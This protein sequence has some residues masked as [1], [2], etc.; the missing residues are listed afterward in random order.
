M[1]VDV[2]LHVFATLAAVIALGS[3]LGRLLRAVGQPAVIGEVAAGI[4]LGPSLLGAVWPAALHQLMPPASL[5]PGGTVPAAIQAVAQLGV[6]LYMFLVGLELDAGQLAGRARATVAVAL[7]GIAVP[8]A[9]GAGLA[10]AL[11]PLYGTDTATPLSFALF[12]G[13]AMAVTAFPVLA[14]ILGDRG[15]DRTEI[16]RLAL[17]AAAA[18]DVIAWCLL[19]GVVG[20]ARAE[21]GAAAR[22]VGGALAFVAIMLLLVRPLARRLARR[23]D[24]DTGP[25]PSGAVSLV[26]LGVLLSALAT[27]VIGIHALFG[28]F[29]F[30]A[31][32]PHDGRLAREFDR[33]LHAPVTVCLLPAFFAATG[34]K[35][36][37]GLVD[38]VSDWLWCGAVVLVATVGKVGGT[39][40]A[41]R[42]TG[43]GWRD[44]LA[45]GAL[46]NTRGLME[47]IVLTV[48]LDLGVI[49]PTVFAMMVLMA[50]ATTL[51]TAPAL[52]ALRVNTVPGER[53]A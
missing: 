19:A 36:R 22:V 1:K 46:M 9:L 6:V 7:A 52:A 23:L 48:G 10:V 37:I 30:G 43:H 21:V 34:M 53:E 28:A 45:V 11:Y 13:V 24:A 51:M 26:F 14:R 31:I 4:L 35:T 29:L 44:A 2:V 42:L 32:L 15:L 20:V 27:E 33:M 8:F 47:L 50:L 25:L 17:A 18:G 39:A 41:A 3:L 12:L 16:G 38:S 40:V 5:D 49:S